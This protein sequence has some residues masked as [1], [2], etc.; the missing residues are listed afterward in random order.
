M[1]KLPD[2]IKAA[3]ELMSKIDESGGKIE[4]RGFRPALKVNQFDIAELT[5]ELVNHTGAGTHGKRIGMQESDREKPTHTC[6]IEST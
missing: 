6:N 4:I 3:I 1:S 2:D 5:G